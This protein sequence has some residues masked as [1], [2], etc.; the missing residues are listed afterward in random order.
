MQKNL[1]VATLVLL[2]NIS[3]T[4]LAQE[5]F[6]I[7]S[8]DKNISVK[9]EIGEII[10]YSVMFKQKEIIHPS[11][12]SMTLDDGRIFSR[13]GKVKKTSLLEPPNSLNGSAL[14]A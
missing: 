13:D 7:N 5:S 4:T 3:F 10:Q 11:S 8:P 14:Y 12:V 2:L 9:I 1:F 6:E